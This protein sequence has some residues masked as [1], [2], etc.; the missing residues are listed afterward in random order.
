MLTP[1]AL[2]ASGLLLHTP[3]SATLSGAGKQEVT[4]PVW[5]FFQDTRAEPT[6]ASQTVLTARALNRRSLRR[7]LPGL[8]DRMDVALDP[9]L[10]QSVASTGATV[11]NESRWLHAVS[12]NATQAQICALQEL[13]GV[14]RV[15][16]V[17]RGRAAW[18]D[19]E[20]TPIQHHSM[21]VPADYGLSMD[22]LAQINLIKLHQYG[23][24][25]AG[26]VIGVL[27]SGFHRVH[28]AF[29]S[30]EHPLQVIAEYDFVK[31]DPNTDIEGIDD[32]SQHNHGTMILGTMA[33]YMPGTYIGGAFEAQ[34]VLCKTEDV[35]TET[36][37]EEDNY[38]AGLEFIEMH[39]ADLSTSSLGYID[40]YSQSDL[41]GATATTT[42]A[43]NIANA[44]GLVTLTAAGNQ[45]HDSNPATS[46]LMA[47]GDAPLML[48]CGSCRSNG[49][50]SSFSSDGPTADGRVKP[51]ILARG[52][53]TNT[54]DP[55]GTNTWVA[56]S[57]TSLSTPLL[58][59]AVAC[60][61][62][63]RP[64]FTLAQIRSALFATAS[65]SAP[66]GTLNPDPLFV[67]GYGIA[68]AFNAA[69]W[70]RPAADLNFDGQVDGTD[71]GLLLGNW[72]AGNVVG[73]LDNSGTVD[74]TDLG[75]LLGQW[76]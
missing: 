39:G 13:P 50:I 64:D 56:A 75:L 19:E 9:R 7:T 8:F 6:D 10:A 66:N 42:V 51:E 68:N 41:D 21:L 60:I 55:N 69:A 43:V 1:I 28:Q 14:V 11:R 57:G 52:S 53:S 44:N 32:P 37:V 49:Q 47:P 73:D 74:G 27:D 46:E 48:T 45:G 4:E 30:A 25:G 20:V 3:P 29:F 22:Q 38:V 63:A 70:G 62:Q 54:I 67:E 59:G 15:E 58:A 18:Q 23:F 71:L 35:P 17:R 5:V 72:G 2:L 40:W 33:G 61:L 16:P 26:M 36:P 31:H 34:F 12:A 24:T 76:Q 65:R